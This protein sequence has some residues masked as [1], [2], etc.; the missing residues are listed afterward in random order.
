MKSDKRKS[1]IY[2]KLANGEVVETSKLAKLFGVSI[3]TIQNDLN[4]LKAV[5]DIKCIKKGYY[6]L[7]KPQKYIDSQI[8]EI[9]SSLIYSLSINTLEEFEDY[10]QSILL[11][12]DDIFLFD[13]KFEEIENIKDLM[14]ILQMTKWNFSITIKYKDVTRTI[15]PLK[16][17][18]FNSYWYLI[19]YDIKDEKIK[20]FHI[21]SI[22]EIKPLFETFLEKNR[23]K[24]LLEYLK[25]NFS[26]WINSNRSSSIFKIF[27]PLDRYIRRKLPLNCEIVE[28]KEEYVKVRFYYFND[29]E[30]INFI[31]NYL[32]YIEV[33]DIELKNKMKQ[34]LKKSLLIL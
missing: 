1:A 22:K 25:S 29:I 30:A 12:K 2:L 24:E 18:N 23:K 4:E 27:S 15:H 20:S 28:D 16:I 6:K 13:V 19:A 5:Y 33:E 26:V 34:I 21:N 3:R 11:K 32:P 8:E 10:I 17:V 9:I 7:E 31:K 14:I